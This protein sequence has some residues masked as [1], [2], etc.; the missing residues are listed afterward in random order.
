LKCKILNLR[1]QYEQTPTEEQKSFLSYGD[2][3]IQVDSPRCLLTRLERSEDFILTL[4]EASEEGRGKRER[5]ERTCAHE[6]AIWFHPTLFFFLILLFIC[7]Y[8]AWVISPPCPQPLPYH[9]SAPSLS[10][11]PPQYPAET[12]LPL[13]LILL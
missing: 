9:H 8:K 3:G 7:A 6:R 4:L 13:F 5:K 1:V 11:P 12:I 2:L 10:P